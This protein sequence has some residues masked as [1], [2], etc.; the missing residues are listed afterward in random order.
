MKKIAIVTLVILILFSGCST[1]SPNAL[2]EQSS[3]LSVPNM[4]ES[5]GPVLV[6]E[7][8]ETIDALMNE[9]NRRHEVAVLTVE[10]A[11]HDM[12]VLFEA[13]QSVYGPYDYFG[14]DKVFLQ[15]QK[16]ILTQ[17]AAK[18]KLCAGA[19][20]ELLVTYL[21]FIRD[22]HFTINGTRF[23]EPIK[24]H[25]YNQG[26]AYLKS[27]EWFVTAD[28]QRMVKTIANTPPG[29]LL[30][31]SISSD[32]EVV[33][34]PVVLLENGIEPEPLEIE[35]SDGSKET[36][37]PPEWKSGYEQS[38]A[39]VALRYK[40][41]IPVVFSRNMYFDQAPGGEDGQ[42][43][44]CYAEQLRE[45]PVSMVDLRSNGGGNGILPLKWLSAFA[46]AQVTTNHLVIQRLSEEDMLAY[47]QDT[48]NQY[49]VP[50][51]KMQIYDG[52]VPIN[53]QY[54]KNGDL[55]DRFVPNQSLLVILTGKNTAS[56]AEI[57]VDVAANVENTLI[58]GQN[59]YGMLLSNAYTSMTLPESGIVIQLGGSLSVF[60]ENSFEEY[61]GLSPDLWVSEAEADELAVKLVQNLM[62]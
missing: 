24:A 13:L 31:L 36:L 56:A 32:G 29:E 18:G 54:M 25:I 22:A 28:G 12:D 61:V 15:A 58:I 20:S 26:S 35:Y 43:F 14:G 23:Y 27:G 4:A 45:A 59:T 53:G 3:A 50:M 16:E 9:M 39:R 49:Y 2:N 52:T 21:N 11:Q 10:Q 41:G 55:P 40:E 5:E 33:Y 19:L 17:C 8:V 42:K 47:E 6:T 34:Y 46:G 44:L 37:L 48:E 38:R 51:E 60:A 57:F 7:R 30:R 62:R 1:V